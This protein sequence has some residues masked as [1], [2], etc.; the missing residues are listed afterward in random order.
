MY[1]LYGISQANTII[2]SVQYLQCIGIYG[3]V[4]PRFE[5]N[6]IKIKYSKKEEE[7]VGLK[8]W[9]IVAIPPPP[10]SPPPKEALFTVQYTFFALN[11]KVHLFSVFTVRYTCFALHGKV[12]L[13]FS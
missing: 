2:N 10:L 8:N 4:L 7:I 3:T 5:D 13:F 9:E 12:H 11:G 6:A 1:V